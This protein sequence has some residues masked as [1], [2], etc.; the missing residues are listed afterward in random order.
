MADVSPN[1]QTAI[2]NAIQTALPAAVDNAIQT[3]LPPALEAV[4]PTVVNDA[5]DDALTPENLFKKIS[6]GDL[7]Q[8][9]LNF[10]GENK[11]F[12]DTVDIIVSAVTTVTDPSKLL[13]LA[14]TLVDDLTPA[15]LR[16][17]F[18]QSSDIITNALSVVG[19]E[20][21]V[22]GIL[23]NRGFFTD[24]MLEI[25]LPSDHTVYKVGL[26]ASAFLLVLE[27]YLLYAYNKIKTD[28][29]TGSIL[30]PIA[31]AQATAFYVLLI[32]AG[33]NSVMLIYL[34]RTKENY[35]RSILTYF[36]H[37]NLLFT[38]CVYTFNKK[39]SSAI[40]NI[41]NSPNLSAQINN[42]SLLS[43]LKLSASINSIVVL[44][45]ISVTLLAWLNIG[46]LDF[47]LLIIRQLIHTFLF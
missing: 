8:K 20:D 41:T 3:A 44:V 30:S 9:A 36:W 14:G 24:L 31:S 7:V 4:L 39:L 5:I 15:K 25:L 33:I 27:L 37:F 34:L 13:G 21:L 18:D 45:F 40:T 11:Y 22:D 46:A 32:S 10:V 16:S 12:M 26:Y 2:D 23:N 38:L 17:V 28:V 43:S 29:G 35:D 19:R 6:I 1:I 42:P 47:F